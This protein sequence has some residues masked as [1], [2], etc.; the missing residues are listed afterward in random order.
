MTMRYV[1]SDPDPAVR[2]QTRPH[3]SYFPQ[4]CYTKPAP[5]SPHQATRQTAAPTA[6]KA[7]AVSLPYIPRLQDPDASH[8]GSLSATRSPGAPRSSNSSSAVL[9]QPASPPP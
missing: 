7:P 9:R 4:A 5:R 1:R 6:D 2:P 3:P 8:T